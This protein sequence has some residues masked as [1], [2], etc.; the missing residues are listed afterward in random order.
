[1]K[2]TVLH[3]DNGRP[4]GSHAYAWPLCASGRGPLQV[5]RVTTDP[6]SVTC[7]K[8]LDNMTRPS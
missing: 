2:A 6:E 7:L 3:L 4:G 1:M 8:C 5:F